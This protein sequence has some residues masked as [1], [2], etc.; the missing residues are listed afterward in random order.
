[1]KKNKNIF[2]YADNGTV[3]GYRCKSD[4]TLIKH[5]LKFVNSL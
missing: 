1:M 3:Q 4:M 5:H 2:F